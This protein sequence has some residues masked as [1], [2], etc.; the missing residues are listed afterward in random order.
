MR[1]T[2][3][4][5][6]TRVYD[7]EV[8]DEFHFY[9]FYLIGNS[10]DKKYQNYTILNKAVDSINQTFTYTYRFA[11]EYHKDYGPNQSW[12]YTYDT[13]QRTYD[14]WPIALD[15]TPYSLGAGGYSQFADSWNATGRPAYGLQA[16]PFI[17]FSDT[18]FSTSS[19]DPA[20]HNET[21]VEGLGCVRSVSNSSQSG[22]TT[23]NGYYLTYYNKGGQTWGT[24]YNVGVEEHAL[25]KITVFPNP[26]A[27][28]LRLSGI[29]SNK[30]LHYVISDLSG[31]MLQTGF[32]SALDPEIDIRNLPAGVHLLTLNQVHVAKFMVIQR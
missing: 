29:Y 28:V 25:E 16:G 32:V 20:W 8:G 15:S 11:E 19:F 31:K 21:Y 2:P 9:N 26:A 4:F 30:P 27:D 1:S 17:V 23:S 24:A 12:T 7:F 22:T 6:V 3:N 13:I 10:G 5:D 14:W 18:C